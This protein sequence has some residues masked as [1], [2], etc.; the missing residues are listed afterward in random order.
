L[1][2]LF[3]APSAIHLTPRRVTV[4]LM[5]AATDNERAAFQPSLDDLG[6]MDLTLLGDPDCRRPTCALR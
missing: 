5:P 2:N 1:A 6:A 4:R 3:A